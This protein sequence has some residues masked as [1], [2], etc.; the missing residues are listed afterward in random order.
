VEAAS[1]LCI[2]TTPSLKSPRIQAI[3]LDIEFPEKDVRQSTVRASKSLIE[4]CPSTGA[5]H[6]QKP[7]NRIPYSRKRNDGLR[8]VPKEAQADLPRNPRRQIQEGNVLWLSCRQQIFH[9]RQQNLLD[10][11]PTGIGKSKL[12]SSSAKNPYAAYSATCTGV[13]CV[14]KIESGRKF[15]NKCA[16]RLQS[17]AICGKKEKKDGAATGVPKVEGAKYTLK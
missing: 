17:C 7:L 8:K 15:C 5:F 2:I 14:T 12:L 9:Q 11:R 6:T 3:Q 1:P 13:D 10:I 4:N 16:Y